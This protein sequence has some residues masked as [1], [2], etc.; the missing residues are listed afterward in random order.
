MQPPANLGSLK[1]GDWQR[2]QEA[3][4]RFEE[5][6]RDSATVDLGQFLPPAGQRKL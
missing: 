4:E 3:A 2:L 1:S 6:W 5:A